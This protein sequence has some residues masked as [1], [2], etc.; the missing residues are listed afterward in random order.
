[1]YNF[2]REEEELFVWRN[3]NTAALL[4]THVGI[5]SS[6]ARRRSKSPGAHH[7][8][9]AI[10]E[11]CF[12]L[13]HCMARDGGP[14]PRSSAVRNSSWLR[15]S[16]SCFSVQ[17]SNLHSYILQLC[18][19]NN[20]SNTPKGLSKQDFLI[21]WP[22]WPFSYF[23]KK[24]LSQII[25]RSVEIRKLHCFRKPQYSKSFIIVQKFKKIRNIWIFVQKSRVSK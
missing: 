8:E 15:N 11:S 7:A 10:L 23:L 25:L 12:K 24:Y 18:G 22:F 2:K 1:M 19:F 5:H 17:F 16:P 13:C 21:L 20:K 14:F 4:T 9:T 3:R 6:E